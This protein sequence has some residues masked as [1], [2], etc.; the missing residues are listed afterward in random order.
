MADMKRIYKYT[1]NKVFDAPH[2][3][4]VELP[5]GAKIIDFE[6]QGPHLYL[7]AVVDPDAKIENVKF[8][9]YGTGLDI[10]NSDELTHLKTVHVNGFIWHIFK[11]N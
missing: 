7:W 6:F 5:I 8:E 10:E 9:I 2:T 4:S 1:I 3:A 11:R